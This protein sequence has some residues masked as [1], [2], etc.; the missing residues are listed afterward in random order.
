MRIVKILFLAVVLL[1]SSSVFAQREA[2]KVLAVPQGKAVIYLVRPS[3]YVGYFRI[4]N[5]IDSTELPNVGGKEYV[6]MVVEPGKHKVVCK[7]STGPTDL[8]VD[9]KAGESVYV[10]IDVKCPFMGVFSANLEIE[11]EEKKIEK[12]IKKSDWVK[13]K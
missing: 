2:E 1:A 11:K 6:T 3:G 8:D 4:V 7:G 10:I 13:K 9:A 5:K 12:F